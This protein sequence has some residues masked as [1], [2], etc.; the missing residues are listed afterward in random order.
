[1]SKIFMA[2]FVAFVVTY[3]PMIATGIVHIVGGFNKDDYK[4]TALDVLFYFVNSLFNPVLTLLY[5]E[6]YRKVVNKM[7][8]RLFKGRERTLSSGSGDDA[9]VTQ[10]TEDDV[11]S[12]GM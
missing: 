12:S 9:T 2:M 10:L 1:M 7:K 6:D 4:Y 11:N 5:K 3:L 8:L